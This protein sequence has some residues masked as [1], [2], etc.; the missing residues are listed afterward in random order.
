MEKNHKFNIMSDRKCK[1][2]KALKLN[3][4]ERKPTARLCFEC[5]RA[6]HILATAREVRTGRIIG[7]KKGIY[8]VA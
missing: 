3:V 5:F 8:V 1:C 6:N 7:R 2:G 4:V